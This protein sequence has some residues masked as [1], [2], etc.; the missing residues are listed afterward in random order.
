MIKTRRTYQTVTPESAE[1]GD[2][3]EAG[4]MFGCFP[5]TDYP[6]PDETDFR[7]LVEEMRGYNFPS[8]SR[9]YSGNTWITSEGEVDYKTGESTE[10][11]LH[12]ADSSKAKYWIK[13]INYVF[14][15]F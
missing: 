8:Q 9:P 4:F 7:G 13:A 6:E 3:S 10:Y 1:A 15:G 12:L 2:Y 11:S 5:V 14:G